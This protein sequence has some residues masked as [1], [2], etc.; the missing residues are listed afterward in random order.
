ML[1]NGCWE[2]RSESRLICRWFI[3][4]NV[5]SNGDMIGSVAGYSGHGCFEVERFRLWAAD[6]QVTQLWIDNADR[7]SGAEINFDSLPDTELQIA[8][9]GMTKPS[10]KKVII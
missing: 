3:A 1:I 8:G 9:S 10:G 7:I 5:Q 4:C 2:N 6:N